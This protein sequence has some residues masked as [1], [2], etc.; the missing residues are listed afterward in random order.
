MEILARKGVLEQVLSSGCFVGQLL[1]QEEEDEDDL[2]MGE[3][4]DVSFGGGEEMD[5]DEPTPSSSA[6]SSSFAKKQQRPP[7]P[8]HLLDLKRKFSKR[9][10]TRSLR[11]PVPSL[12]GE[13]LGNGTLIVPGW[14]RERV[15]EDLFSFKKAGEGRDDEREELSV[16]EA[17]LGVLLKVSRV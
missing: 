9:S 6:A 5:V 14:I 1:S 8:P 16:V 4:G 7:L 2:M 13:G 10:T 12:P 17:V 15:A 11:V 3:G